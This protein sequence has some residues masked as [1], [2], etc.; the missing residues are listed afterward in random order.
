MS[1]PPR[2]AALALALLAALG[3]HGPSGPPP[4]GVGLEPLFADRFAIEVLDEAEEL[5]EPISTRPNRFF[6]GW[7]PTRSGGRRAL[8]SEP[9]GATL[10]VAIVEPGPRTVALDLLPPA[11]TARPAHVEV[12]VDGGPGRPVPV[13][14]PLL[15]PLPA[16]LAPGRHQVRIAP[17]GA[18]RTPIVVGSGQVRG[19]TPGGSA[20]L[21]DGGLVQSA[22]SIVDVVAPPG[23]ARRLTGEL[24][25]PAR[26]GS[27]AAFELEVE[28][29]GGETLGRW[30]SDDGPLG[31][32]ASHLGGCRPI[33]LAVAASGRPLRVRLR[34]AGRGA[35][36]TWRALAWSRIPG[37]E[38]PEAPAVRA[39]DPAPS[40]APDPAPNPPP[41]AGAGRP[42]PPRLVVLYV[43]DALRADRVG[44]LGGP[45]GVSPTYDRLA[46]EGFLFRAHRSVAP[47]TLPSTR[48]LFTGR[49]FLTRRSWERAG[50]D[51]P[52][53]AEAFR[54]AGYRTG[55]F[56]GNAYVSA[57]FG[58][59]RGFEH[60][61]QA[62]LLDP[63]DEPAGG[64]PPVN[65]NAE[66]VHA[67]ALSWLAGLPP[68]E[69]AFLYLHT[70]H[71]HN[72]Y[73]PPPAF[74]R[75]FTAGIPSA[76]DGRTRTLLAIEK[77]R[78][79]T[80][81][82][83]RE[84]LAGLYAASLAYEDAELARFVAALR[85]RYPEREIFLILTAD[86][87][88]ELFDHGGALH[89]FT[90]YEE[91]LHV[92]LVLWSPGR[93]AP[94][95]S[96]ELTDA[97]D[98]HATL[99]DLLGASRP[100]DPGPGRSLL[101]L[102]TGRASH[103]AARPSFAGAANV[104]GGFAAIRDGRWKLIRVAGERH[105]WA[106]GRG[107]GRS[108]SRDY[109]F[110]L[111]TDPGERRNL[112]GTGGIEEQWLRARLRAWVQERKAAGTAIGSGER[113]PAAPDLDEATR[114]RLEA[115]GYVD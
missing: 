89:G 40:P 38:G 84:R 108:W 93:V 75:R 99:L 87:G 24:C 94:G 58:L 16:D 25:R 44:A 111:A 27:V 71:P 92:P 35:P 20:R 14:D 78:R 60:V 52:T 51:R 83:D 100:G 81:A 4:S 69:R 59:A 65:R 105:G 72:P 39:A 31:S 18:A 32:L 97:L 63:L 70:I 53:L 6:G 62:A 22:P 19:A 112:A 85:R 110:D 34:A 67:A 95:A 56:S 8:R 9:A 64:A 82:A 104:P 113:A 13:A 96:D 3:C 54:H 36:G 15:L 77:G 1:R 98:L 86:H 2:R 47:N 11:G 23:P 43:M 91:L 49:V 28:A 17:R 21:G 73:A 10:Q 7:I 79:A 42:A 74:E 48:D 68:G 33:A 50:K 103:L 88:D 107:P 55:L 90:L 46:R 61:S 76:I 102:A 80:S 12:R 106:M 29:A 37:P 45:E 57:R 101:P 26:L 66:Q 41:G 30:R 109:L 5:A 115:L 114:R